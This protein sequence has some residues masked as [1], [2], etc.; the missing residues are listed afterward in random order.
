MNEAAA[1]SMDQTP[2]RLYAT[3]PIIQSHLFM[4]VLFVLSKSQATILPSL[5]KMSELNLM[6]KTGW[7]HLDTL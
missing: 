2:K 4:S 6:C 7:T 1:A 5:L 3:F